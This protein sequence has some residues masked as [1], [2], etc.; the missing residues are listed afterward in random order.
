MEARARRY[1][2]VKWP[3]S[4]LRRDILKPIHERWCGEGQTAVVGEQSPKHAPRAAHSRHDES[5]CSFFD[6]NRVYHGGSR[7]A[8]R[9]NALCHLDGTDGY[10]LY[11][12]SIVEQGQATT[13]VASSGTRVS[14]PRGHTHRA[15]YAA[16]SVPSTK[17]SSSTLFLQ[18]E[19]GLCRVPCAHNKQRRL[20]ILRTSPCGSNDLQH[21]HRRAL[22]YRR[23]AAPV[24]LPPRQ[25]V[26]SHRLP[27]RL[28][29]T[30]DPNLGPLPP[31]QL[32]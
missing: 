3:E 27:L 17:Q 6:P 23:E 11:T 16:G 4:P 14:R 13:G 21:H 20:A 25:P 30:E 24:L 12:S 7:H 29:P 1:V 26:R 9:E 28:L 8:F 31:R 19:G 15:I 5:R 32:P 18:A 10:R 2:T 22:A